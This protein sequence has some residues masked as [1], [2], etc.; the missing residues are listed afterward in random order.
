MRL[1]S[2]GGSCQRASTPIFLISANAPERAD[3]HL[4]QPHPAAHC[5]NVSINGGTRLSHE[6]QQSEEINHENEKIQEHKGW[7]A[8]LR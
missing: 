3:P 2:T 4:R 6:Q 7:Q 5:R 8:N 1:I